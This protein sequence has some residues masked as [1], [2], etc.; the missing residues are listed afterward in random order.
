MLFCL[1]SFILDWDFVGVTHV[2]YS[3]YCDGNLISTERI[4][5]DAIES[6]KVLLYLIHS[7]L[8]TDVFVSWRM[9]LCTHEKHCLFSVTNR[10]FQLALVGIFSFLLLVDK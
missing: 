4:N 1:Q 7:T 3:V 2:L 10:K 9:A 5:W 8:N 6:T